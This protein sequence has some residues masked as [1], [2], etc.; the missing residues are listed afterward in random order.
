MRSRGSGDSDLRGISNDSRMG[1]GKQTNL[2]RLL[3]GASSSDTV[4]GVRLRGTG[5]A[6]A[7]GERDILEL[8]S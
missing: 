8:A 5:E 7:D 3:A 6:E 2:F 4:D 1:L